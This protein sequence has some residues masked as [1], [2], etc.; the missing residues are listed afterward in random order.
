MT[1]GEILTLNSNVEND[2]NILG[3]KV[4]FIGTEI[5]NIW[6]Y[7]RRGYSSYYF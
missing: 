1:A 6:N 4:T 2:G 3:E 5:K 7:H